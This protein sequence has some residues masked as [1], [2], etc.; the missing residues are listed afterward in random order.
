LAVMKEG[1]LLKIL[2]RLNEIDSEQG[3]IAETD[4]P[5]RPS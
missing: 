5:L 3:P 4:K 1:I 2:K